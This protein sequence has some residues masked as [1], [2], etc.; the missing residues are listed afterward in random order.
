[1]P[2]T[3]TLSTARAA[4]TLYVIVI[5]LGLGAELGIRLPLVAPGDPEAT[6]AAVSAALGLFRLGILADAGMVLADIGLALLFY[7][8]LRPVAAGPAM[9]AMVLRLMQAAVIAASAL[10]LIAAAHLVD[11]AATP[12]P[13]SLVALIELHAAGYDFGLIFFAVNTAITAW[14]L[15]RS[16]LVPRWLPPLLGA[17]AAVYLLGSVTQIV[18]PGINELMQPAYLQKIARPIQHVRFQ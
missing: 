4:G 14:L 6:W 8:L 16:G 5:L 2:T 15:G 17:A 9:A 7:R 3:P 10:A 18:A 1:M 12:R 11:T 13:E